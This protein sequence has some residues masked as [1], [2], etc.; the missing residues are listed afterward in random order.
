MGCW[1]VSE[2]G[3]ERCSG[4]KGT[5]EIQVCGKDESLLKKREIYYLFLNSLLCG[6]AMPSSGHPTP[7]NSTTPVSLVK[8]P[9]GNDTLDG[10]WKGVQEKSEGLADSRSRV[11]IKRHQKLLNLAEAGSWSPRPWDSWEGFW[12]RPR[13]R[14]WGWGCCC[15]AIWITLK[16]RTGDGEPFYLSTWDSHYY[17]KGFKI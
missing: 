4:N 6:S 1:S 12:T 17:R 5:R 2:L 11:E 3:R 9:P 8:L 13:S 14:G 16:L 15:C 7:R 10:R